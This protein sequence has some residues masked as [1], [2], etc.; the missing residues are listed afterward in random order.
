MLSRKYYKMIA[1]VIKD[2]KRIGT[3]KKLNSND[4]ILSQWFMDDLCREL[5]IDNSLFNRDTFIE[6]CN[7]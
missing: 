3:N 1:R 6:A 5:K 7:D 2:N 4:I